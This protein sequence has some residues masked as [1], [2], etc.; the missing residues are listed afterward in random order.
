[1]N[2]SYRLGTKVPFN[3]RA[4]G[5]ADNTDASEHFLR[6][7]DIMSKGVGVSEDAEY[8]V[9]PWLT[10]DPETEL[11]VGDFA[12]E[13]NALQKDENREGFKIPTIEEL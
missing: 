4:G 8:V 9:G 13:A 5:F 7:H 11:H 6:L 2:N 3:E 1:M 10:Y 12:D